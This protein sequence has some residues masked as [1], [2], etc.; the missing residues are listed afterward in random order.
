MT[1]RFQSLFCKITRIL[2]TAQP[3]KYFATNFLELLISKLAKTKIT[4]ELI[5]NVRVETTEVYETQN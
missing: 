1:L 4:S 3:L 2:D 5:L